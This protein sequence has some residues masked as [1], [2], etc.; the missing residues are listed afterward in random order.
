[1]VRN[2]TG[3]VV[4]GIGAVAIFFGALLS[5][6]IEPFPGTE[7][8]IA[9]EKEVFIHVAKEYREW[10]SGCTD[11][12]DAVKVRAID[13]QKEMDEVCQIDRTYPGMHAAGCF[14][15]PIPL[16]YVDINV[17][18]YSIL[19]HELTHTLG[20]CIG[21][22]DRLDYKHETFEW[23]GVDGVMDRSHKEMQEVCGVSEYRQ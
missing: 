6:C 22:V 8:N 7:V 15:P 13:D 1:M 11:F 10:N 23:W 2:I 21:G 14:T 20:W 12:V 18:P 5:S 17:D 19:S 9:C 4:A 3:W 16:I